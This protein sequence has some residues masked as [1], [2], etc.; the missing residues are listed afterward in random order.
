MKDQHKPTRWRLP[1]I[2][3][4]ITLNCGI[5]RNSQTETIL[6]KW[7]MSV[8][9]RCQNQHL[10]IR[11]WKYLIH[12]ACAFVGFDILTAKST[13]SC[14]PRSRLNNNLLQGDW[15]IFE[16]MWGKNSQGTKFPV[17]WRNVAGCVRFRL[18]FRL[19]NSAR[20]MFV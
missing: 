8:Q 13:Y 6:L 10:H 18:T 11:I 2:R 4:K 20:N 3:Y 16:K 19:S 17:G 1:V 15:C 12:T 9:I 14:L 5:T 7:H